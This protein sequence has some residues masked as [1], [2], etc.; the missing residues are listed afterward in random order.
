MHLKKT[1]RLVIYSFIYAFGF[2]L[3]IAPSELLATG[4]SGVAQIIVQI[5][6]VGLGLTYSVVY[7]A[8]NVPGFVLS[9]KTMGKEFTLNTILVVFLMSFF[10]SAV[11]L[12]TNGWFI[13]NDVIL[14]CVFGGL[15]MGYAVGAILKQGAS[16]GGTDIFGLYLL[17][18]RN[19]SFTSVNMAM[20]A[21]II[22][23]AL[24]IFGM[25]AGLYTLLSLYVRNAT[26]KF[27]FTNNELVTLFII[28]E[29]SKVVQSL[30]TMKLHRGTT[31]LPG[32]GGFTHADK[33]VVMTTLN[34]YEYRLFVNLLDTY[35][36]EKIFVN[37]VD[38]R[39]IIGNY[40]V[41]KN[42]A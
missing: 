6:P 2:Q 18:T 20:N 32:Y 42:K 9:Y 10:T 21:V 26:I 28:T 3:F 25:E 35:V 1:L 14:Q 19:M 12:F 34:Q 27:V 39:D 13:T 17:K 30:I 4:F 16:S 7:F 5:A 33:E 41:Q 8:L 37:V 22:I 40:N 29:D 36:D 11:A 24:K 31:I 15:T 23:F 38:T